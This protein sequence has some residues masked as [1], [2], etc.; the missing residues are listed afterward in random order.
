MTPLSIDA[1]PVIARQ[2]L[3]V[4][5]LQRFCMRHAMHHPALTAFIDHVWKVAQLQAG[6]FAAW[7]RGFAALPI[8]GMGDPW[9]D[10]IRLAI[11]E[12]MLDDLMALVQHVMETSASTWHG[13]DLAASRRQL[14]AVLRICGRHGVAVP[15]LGPHAQHAA[16]PGKGW[17]SALTD[18]EVRAWKGL[19]AT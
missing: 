8:S 5:C 11:P 1:L 17:G 10:D 12:T 7:E 14:E 19:A 9:P 16:R 13:D 2:C 3:A 6:E 15:E 4:A 18:A